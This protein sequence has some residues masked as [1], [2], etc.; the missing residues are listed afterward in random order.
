M[1]VREG[2]EGLV[3]LPPL[4]GRNGA[5]SALLAATLDPAMLTYGA[6]SA[7]FAVTLS[8]AMLTYAAASALLTDTPSPAM[9]TDCTDAL[10][11]V[12]SLW[13]LNHTRC[14]FHL[15][16]RFTSQLH[17]H[18]DLVCEPSMRYYS[19]ILWPA[20][21]I[22]DIRLHRLVYFW[23]VTPEVIMKLSLSIAPSSLGFRSSMNPCFI[24]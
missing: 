9:L 14:C 18:C 13:S 20:A 4:S 15:P 12:M 19:S 11:N 17:V 21:L 6:A 8:P 22:C 1:I 24:N 3:T 2:V 5:A 10:L 7:L 16:C 23:I